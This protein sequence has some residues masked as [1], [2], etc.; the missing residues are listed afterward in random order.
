MAS[1]PPYPPYPGAAPGSTLRHPHWWQRP[2]VRYG[3]VV[4]LLALSGLVILALVRSRPVRRDSWSV[5]GWPCCRCRCCSRRS[6]GWAG[7]SR[8]PGG[9]CCSPSPGARARRR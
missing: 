7:W 8:A 2:A 5:W 1:S 3:A 4:T 9:T 6:A